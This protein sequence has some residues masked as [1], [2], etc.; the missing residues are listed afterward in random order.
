MRIII[1][2]RLLRIPA[3]VSNSGS[4]EEFPAL[5]QYKHASEMI[6][7][8]STCVRFEGKG[9]GLGVGVAGALLGTGVGT[10]NGHA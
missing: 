7:A 3:M 4:P 9:V 1:R 5:W 8:T 6:P 2:S 10:G